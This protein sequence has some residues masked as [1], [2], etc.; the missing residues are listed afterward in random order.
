MQLFAETF[1]GPYDQGMP[2]P[3]PRKQFY[4]AHIEQCLDAARL[5]PRQRTLAE[6]V[7]WSKLRC[8]A[9]HLDRSNV[10]E[11]TE[12]ALAHGMLVVEQAAKLGR[13][14]VPKAQQLQDFVLHLTRP[15]RQ[16]LIDA[17]ELRG[18]M[19]YEGRW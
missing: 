14:R 1:P 6:S 19:H 11:W 17:L 8:Y 15:V 16:R 9:R 13:P 5:T 2:K 18:R 3:S 12:F 4:L 10:E 7:T